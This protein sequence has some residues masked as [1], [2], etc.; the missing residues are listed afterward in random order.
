MKYKPTRASVWRSETSGIAKPALTGLLVL[1]V[2]VAGYAAIFRSSGQPVTRSDPYGLGVD[3]HNRLIVKYRDAVGAAAVADA[4]E[5]LGASQALEISQ[6]R[7]KVFNTPE[8]QRERIHQV[9]ATDPSVEYVEY[10]QLYRLASTAP[11]DPEW[12]SQAG[13]KYIGLDTLWESYTGDKTIKIGVV[14]SGLKMAHPDF[15]GKVLPGRDFVNNDN[16]PFDDNG[17]GTATAMT[18][19]ALGGNKIGTAGVCWKCSVLPVK[20]MSGSGFGISTAIANGIRYAADNGAAVIN[21]SIGTGGQTQLEKDAVTYAASKGALLVASAGNNNSE[22]LNYPAAYPEVLSVAA[23][24]EASDKRAYYSSFGNTVDI[25]APGTVI[26]ADHPDAN[27]Y[28][29]WMGTSFSTPTVA[30]FAGLLLS[31]FPEAT[32][33]EII[34]AMTKTAVAC[35]DNKINGGR[36]NPQSAFDFLKTKYPNP[37]ATPPPTPTPTPTP[38]PN[39]TPKTGDLNNDGKVNI[40]DL[41]ILLSDWGKP[42][43][44]ADLN[45]SGKVDIADLSIL[46]SNWTK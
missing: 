42:D 22:S 10:E 26:A 8:G 35:C 1:V 13:F 40:T 14:D 28:K 25:A 44:Q 39:P 30:G 16:D 7:V 20:V 45:N 5:R 19:A 23:T 11:D 29:A 46:L 17:H 6:L 2:A 24:E 33:A 3:F 34:E 36:L 38:N 37:I 9:L 15:A 18:A 32:N 43:V 41:S 12:S 4:A 31:A 21:M 27:Q